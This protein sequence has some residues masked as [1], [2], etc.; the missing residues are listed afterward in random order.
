[1]DR[2]INILNNG[3]GFTYYL[4][5][6]NDEL[7]AN[8]ISVSLV[9]KCGLVNEAEHEQGI[10][11]FLE[12]LIALSITYLPQ[13]YERIF[14]RIERA[15]T[16]MSETVYVFQ[17]HQENSEIIELFLNGCINTIKYILFDQMLDAR[18][19]GYAKQEVLKEYQK[20]N[21]SKERA[22]KKLFFEN[23]HYKGLPIGCIDCIDKLCFDD[24]LEYKKKHY[25]TEKSAII[26]AGNI[27]VIRTEDV[28]KQNFSF[29]NNYYPSGIFDNMTITDS[30]HNQE[31]I[32]TIIKERYFEK[33]FYSKIERKVMP[34][35]D[36]IEN[37]LYINLA[38]NSVKLITKNFFRNLSIDISE[39]DGDIKIFDYNWF[40]I[41]FYYTS[42]E[43]INFE[44]KLNELRLNYDIYSQTIADFM[45]T[46]EIDIKLNNYQTK[47][48]CINHFLFQEPILKLEDEKKHIHRIIDNICFYKAEQVF[49]EIVRNFVSLEEE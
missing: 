46:M 6:Q 38:L 16:G 17:S 24:L 18:F 11:H 49:D 26:I 13:S 15:Y 42:E 1:M 41:C 27:D 37:S 28:I 30:C 48:E 3:S 31:D 43:D 39:V 4:V 22:V 5:N 29:N 9:I 14:S 35:D 7:K 8:E 44:I 23:S 19:F 33:T 2:I 10:S 40:V 20:T 25:L 32:D 12:H 36:Y 45:K 47:T 34:I 21:L